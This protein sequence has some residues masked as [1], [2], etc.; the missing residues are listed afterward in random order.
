MYFCVPHFDMFPTSVW[1]KDLLND[2]NFTALYILQDTVITITAFKNE[3]P[4]KN[5]FWLANRFVESCSSKSRDRN[6]NKTTNGW[7]NTAEAQAI[8]FLQRQVG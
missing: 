8:S 1:R 2:V 3:K 5:I 6:M 7:L 4:T